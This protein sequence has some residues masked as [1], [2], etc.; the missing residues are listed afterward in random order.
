MNLEDGLRAFPPRAFALLN[1]AAVVCAD[2]L[3]VC[4][5]RCCHQY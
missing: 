3:Q 4:Q 5:Y 2:R 1:S